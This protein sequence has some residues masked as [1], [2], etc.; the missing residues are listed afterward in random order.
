MTERSRL[1]LSA[2]RLARKRRVV[3]STAVLLAIA[4]LAL[5]DCRVVAQ[6]A[7]SSLAPTSA[8]GQAEQVLR[9]K[10]AIAYPSVTRWEIALLPSSMKALN[11]GTGTRPSISVTRLGARSAVWVGSQSLGQDRHG[12]LLWFNVAGYAQ[13]LVAARP[14][15]AGATLDSGDGAL[16]ER[17]IV[18]GSCNPV[19]DARA[20]TGKRAKHF[21]QVGEI[22]CDNLLEPVPAVARGEEVALLYVGRTFTLVAKAVAQADGTVGKRVSVRNVSS[23]EVF[24]ATVTGKG[25]VSVNE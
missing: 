4:W 13:A 2:H 15:S 24:A 20:L 23:G 22:I 7:A 19:R 9:S 17:D 6:D 10:L 8:A 5:P 18:G 14:L 16:V 11:A 1:Q 12:T 21:F 25:E 3:S